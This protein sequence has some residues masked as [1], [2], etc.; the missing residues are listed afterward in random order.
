M[1]SIGSVTLQVADLPAAECFYESAFALDDRLRLAAG[2]EETSG[3]RGYTLSVVVGQPADVDPLFDA[4]LLGGA[5]ELK[6]AKKQFWGGYSGVVEAPDGAIWKV[7][8][9]AKKNRGP[10]TRAIEGVTLILGTADI[11]ASRNF[12]TEQGLTVAK[13]Y[14]GRYVE[15]EAATN[16]IRLGLYKRRGLAKDAGVPVEG[17]G[18]HRLVIGSDSGRFTDPDGFVWALGAGSGG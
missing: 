1:N 5:R 12:Y 4:A 8:T 13:K 9:E 6:P 16:S 15:F 7:A 14:G 18:S 2:A 3:F 17:S 10:A 11:A